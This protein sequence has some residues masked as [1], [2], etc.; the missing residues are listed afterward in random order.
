MGIVSKGGGC[1][2]S[3]QRKELFKNRPSGSGTGRLDWASSSLAPHA[4]M[5]ACTQ[6]PLLASS[7]YLSMLAS[8]SQ[9]YAMAW[10]A[11]VHVALAGRER[12]RA[13]RDASVRVPTTERK[14]NAT[15]LAGRLLGRSFP[16]RPVPGRPSFS[17][18][19]RTGA[20]VAGTV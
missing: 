17:R 3:G 11:S 10:H 19:I 14:R 2:G 4:C 13:R 12:A 15:P 8:Q 9:V 20:A 6:M 7:I 1:T 18:P 5:H 16:I